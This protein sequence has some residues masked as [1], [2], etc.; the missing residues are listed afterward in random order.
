M[1]ILSA[2]ITLSKPSLIE[3]VSLLVAINFRTTTMLDLLQAASLLETKLII[4]STISD[5][6]KGARFLCADLKDHFLASPMKD[7]EFMR[8]RYKYFPDAIRKQYNLDQFVTSTGYIYIRIKKGMYRLKQAA[9]LA[10]KHL[11]NTAI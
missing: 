11:V 7:P 9:L 4:N 8:I 3:F 10:Y 1:A 5:A 6:D 2:I